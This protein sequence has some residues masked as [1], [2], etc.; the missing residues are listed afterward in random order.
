MSPLLLLLDMFWNTIAGM[1][2]SSLTRLVNH[3][4]DG[5]IGA[6]TEHY[7]RTF[8]PGGGKALDI[9]SSWVSHYPTH[10]GLSRVDITGMNGPEMDKNPVAAHSI[11][12]DLNVEPVLPY[13]D[14]SFDFVTCVVSIDYLSN[15]MAVFREVNRVLKPGGMFINSFSNRCFPSKVTAVWSNTSD[16][17]HVWI[18][19]SFYQYSG[20]EQIE[21]LDLKSEERPAGNDP[22]YVVQG[23]KP[24]EDTV[25]SDL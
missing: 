18:V 6:L 15:P 7:S 19:G 22:M 4:D 21:M 13:P 2:M 23:R 9:C 8:T 25:R 1:G 16:L 10:H 12:K 14:R 20:F 24:A 11:V 17:Q 5:A 3:I